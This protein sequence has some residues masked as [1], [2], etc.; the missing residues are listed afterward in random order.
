MTTLFAS[1]GLLKAIEGKPTT[2]LTGGGEWSPEELKA[3][4]PR[5]V[6]QAEY[7]FRAQQE[8]AKEA[9]R[10]AQAIK[11]T[12]LKENY[13]NNVKTVRSYVPLTNS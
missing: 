10:V 11:N 1:N 7:N 13:K 5:Q 12:V 2:L 3:M 9:E 4:T 8:I 6:T